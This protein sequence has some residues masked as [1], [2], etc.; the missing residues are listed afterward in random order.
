M[1][2]IH[3]VIL[4][5]I[6]SLP[7]TA[8][9]WGS[10][11]HQTVCDVAWRAMSDDSRREVTQLIKLSSYQTFAESCNW[12]DHIRSDR[13]K[14]WLNPYHYVNI[15][16]SATEVRMNDCSNKGCVL[17]GI[18]KFSKSFI[19]SESAHERL[20]ALM[21]I[22]HFVGDLHQPLHVSYKDDKGGNGL[23]VKFFGENTNLHKVWDTLIIERNQNSSWNELGEELYESAVNDITLEDINLDKISWANESLALTRQIYSNLPGNKKLSTDYITSYKPVIEK[24]IQ[25]AGM[26]LAHLV[27]ELTLKRNTHFETTFDTTLNTLQFGGDYYEEIPAQ[28]TGEELHKALHQL[29]SANKI[30]LTYKEVWTA[31]KYTDEDPAIPNNVILLYSGR[32]QNKSSRD[33]GGSAPDSWNREHVWSKSHGFKKKSDPRYTDIHHLRPA[34][35]SVNSSRGNKDFDNGGQPHNE[36]AGAF[37]DS[38]S[39]E[40]PNRVKGDTARMMFYMATAYKNQLELVNRETKSGEGKFG[41]LCTLYKWHSLDPVDVWEMKRND[42]IYELQQNRNPYIDHPE[43]VAAVWGSHCS[44]H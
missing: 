25:Y 18:D 10:L 23:K 44:T 37:S 20:E 43:Y 34:D 7:N 27:D 21:L 26:R 15:S 2:K 28:S 6:L 1:F 22:G 39:F 11:G 30:Q 24:R 36:V 14:K 9:A 38:D 40:P 4:I 5:S 41:H 42:R 29:I 16:R 19:E 8:F 35:K 3:N 13:D 31:L 33:Q 12:P 17:S 32:S